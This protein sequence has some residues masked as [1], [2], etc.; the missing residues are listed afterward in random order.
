MSSS[1]EHR[2]EIAGSTVGD[3]AAGAAA[4]RPVPHLEEEHRSTACPRPSPSSCAGWSTTAAGRSRPPDEQPRAVAASDVCLLFR[5]FIA[6]Q[7]D[8]TKTYVEALEARGVPH[9]LVGGKTFHEREEVDAL[10]TALA[11]IE[12]PE[13]ELSIFAT[14]RGPLFAIG[15]E[16][17]L[18]YHRAR[19][20]EVSRACVSSLPRPGW[21]AG[22]SGADWRGARRASRAACGPQLSAGCRHHR[23]ADRSHARAR[24][25]MLWRGGEQVLANVLHIAELARQYEAEGGLSFRGFVETLRSAAD[26]AQAPEA[27][28]LEEGS[29]GVRLMTVH[30]AKGLEFPVVILADISCGLSRDDAQRYLD[31]VARA[32]LRHAPGRMG[33]ARSAGKQRAR[34]A[35]ATALRACGWRTLPR[36]VRAI[37]SSFPRSAIEPFDDGW[38]APLNRGALSADRGSAVASAV[39][40]LSGVQGP[41]HGARAS[42]R[43]AAG[44]VPRASRADT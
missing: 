9:L 30:K 11:A 6:Y 39:P 42:R 17:L 23:S 24:G 7:D 44:H 5:R 38:V 13:D 27:P 21:P 43:R 34:S 15:D 19:Q 40:W 29:E 28:I 12:W 32:A 2:R 35:S 36:R 10:R 41:R 22:A 37:C 31:P 20:R 1:A 14:L 16:E 8:V 26:R 3:C 4:V 18:E 33:A 25:F